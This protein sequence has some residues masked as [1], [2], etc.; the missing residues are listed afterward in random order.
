MIQ[1][2]DIPENLDLLNRWTIP[3]MV[4]Q[5]GTFEKLGLKQIVKTTESSFPL[6]EE[7]I[8]LKLLSKKDILPLKRN[9]NFLYMLC[10]NFFQ[11]SYFR[12]TT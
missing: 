6:H 9:Y 10:S 7:E 5:L 8:V 1:E 11:A 2:Y 3:K 12:R 4:Y